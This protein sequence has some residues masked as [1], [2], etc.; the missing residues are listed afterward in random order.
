MNHSTKDTEKVNKN[1]KKRNQTLF[2][3]P[4]LI[5]FQARKP[6]S[7]THYVP[8]NPVRKY[9]T[10]T[11]FSP[12]NTVSYPILRPHRV[13]LPIKICKKNHHTLYPPFNRVPSVFVVFLSFCMKM[14]ATVFKDF[15]ELSEQPIGTPVQVTFD[16]WEVREF[17][18]KNFKLL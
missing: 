7:H 13:C 17:F 11:G 15:D 12:G 6:Y 10:D 3:I 16:G 2:E 8:V 18:F 9:D 1:K 5:G 14:C 4:F